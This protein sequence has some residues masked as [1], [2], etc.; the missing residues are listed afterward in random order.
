MIITTDR[1]IRTIFPFKANSL[2]TPKTALLAAGILLIIV[3][4]LNSHMLLPFFGGLL[5]GIP[6]LAC[7]A[8]GVDQAY[9]SFYFLKW[10]IVQVSEG[11]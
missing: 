4:G 10:T 3:V 6:H 7:A 11:W 9:V 5:P 1:W 2:C 8:N